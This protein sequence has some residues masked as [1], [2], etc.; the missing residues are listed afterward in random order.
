MQ[1]AS[2]AA[3]PANVGAAPP[4]VRPEEDGND[5]DMPVEDDAPMTPVLAA[6]AP[7]A[8]ASTTIEDTPVTSRGPG[9]KKGFAT[10]RRA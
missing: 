10:K 2:G 1:A 3:A 5:V 8:S 9:P 6:T 4:E 7:T